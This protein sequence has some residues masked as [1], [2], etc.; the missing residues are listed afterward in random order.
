MKKRVGITSDEKKRKRDWEIELGIKINDW[1]I[2]AKNLTYDQAQAKENEY[3]KQGYKGSPGGDR[4]V[5]AIY[6]VYTFSY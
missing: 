1:N 6:S 2:V 3:I 5:G 4:K